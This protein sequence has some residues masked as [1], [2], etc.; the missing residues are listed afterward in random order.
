MAVDQM[1]RAATRP[2]RTRLDLVLADGTEPAA[3]ELAAKET[4]CCSFFSF[5]FHAG[6][7]GPVMQVAVPSSYVAVLDARVLTRVNR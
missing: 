1:V 4:S 5:T 3:R 7:T 2:S 6:E